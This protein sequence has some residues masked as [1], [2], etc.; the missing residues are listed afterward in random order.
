MNHSTSVALPFFVALALR[1]RA[2]RDHAPLNAPT[3]RGGDN[4][5]FDRVESPGHAKSSRPWEILVRRPDLRRFP[6]RPATARYGTPGLRRPQAAAYVSRMSRVLP[7][8]ACLLAAG[9]ARAQQQEQGLVER[10]DGTTL[11]AIKAMDSNSKT[12]PALTSS[13]GKKSYDSGS[14]NTKTYGTGDYLGIKTAT[15]KTFSTRSFLGLKNPWFGRKVYDT[16]ASGLASRS[17]GG[18]SRQFKTDSFE[19]KKFDGGGKADLKD[20]AAPL[21]AGTE[22]RP[23]LV[24]PKAQGGVDQF[25][26]N[27]KKDLT[28]DDVRDLLNKGKGN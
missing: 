15:L 19:A 1:R 8:V 10:I 22:P 24:A 27:L 18:S 14:F 21:P 16:G 4:E 3:E 9:F 25:T 13:L 23:Y 6:A 20:G 28:I 26:Q 12:D 5:V 2:A 11:K 7:L 17:A